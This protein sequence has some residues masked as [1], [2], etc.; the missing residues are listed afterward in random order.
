MH[1]AVRA[2]AP[3]WLPGSDPVVAF[4]ADLAGRVAEM[5]FAVTCAVTTVCAHALDPGRRIG[6]GKG[7]GVGIRH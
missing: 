5:V 1:P 2:L 6:N 4:P 7:G 3:G